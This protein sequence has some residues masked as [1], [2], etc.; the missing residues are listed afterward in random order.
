MNKKVIV[1]FLIFIFIIFEYFNTFEQLE[2]MARDFNFRDNGYI[3]SRII[4]IGIDDESLNSIGKWP[5]KRETHAELLNIIE[6]GSPAVIGF[7]IM[8]SENDD[9]LEQDK[10]LSETLGN[11]DNIIFPVVGV[12]D[13]SLKAN[14]VIA[15]SIIKPVGI[16]EKK[17]NTG[18]INVIPDLDGIVR[19]SLLKFEYNDELIYSFSWEIYSM[20]I[21]NNKEVRNIEESKIPVDDWNRMQIN[22]YGKPFDMECISYSSV[23]NG[24]IPVEYFKNK[25]VLVGA[26][27]LGINDYYL[28]S[29]ERQVPMYGIE[30]HANIIQNFLDGNLKANA[31][32]ILNVFILLFIA[33]F[34]Y[35]FINKLT[36]VKSSILITI[37]II[38]YY[39]ISIKI[40]KMG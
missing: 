34:S 26:Y 4:I 3:D 30:I 37:I 13:S 19:N 1:V 27:S 9:D 6:K 10:I 31:P 16:L 39:I 29:I 5:W 8:L 23:L 25:I 11:Y 33:V 28:T 22:F 36:I 14:N 38:L 18:H 35:F 32:F 40:Y 17:V 20:Y 21:K 15:K 24:E 12:F 2:S 7:D